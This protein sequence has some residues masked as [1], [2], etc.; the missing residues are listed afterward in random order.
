MFSLNFHSDTSLSF[1]SWF[2]GLSFLVDCLFT[3][4]DLRSWFLSDFLLTFSYLFY[5]ISSHN[6]SCSF[7]PVCLAKVHLFAWFPFTQP[8]WQMLS[9]TFS[10]ECLIVNINLTNLFSALLLYKSF[11]WNQPYQPIVR[12]DFVLR[13]SYKK[14]I[15]THAWEVP[16]K[17]GFL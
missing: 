2:Y 14:K 15:K 6:F 10:F 9:L 3:F 12:V 1:T 4:A 5:L 11:Q 16:E 13:L 7:V 8:K 17:F